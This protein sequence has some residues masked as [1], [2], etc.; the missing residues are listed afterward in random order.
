MDKSIPVVK[1]E[2]Y[3]INI[4]GL[5]YEGEGVGKLDGFTIFV[6]GALISEKVKIKIIKVNK[7][8]AYGKLLEIIEISKDR[9]EPPCNIYKKCGG[10]Q[11]QHLS[12]EGQLEFKK[13]RVK[14]C[15]SKIAKLDSNLVKDTLGMIG[16]EFRYRNK[17]QLPLANEAGE[18]K[19][20]FYAKRSHN[21]IQMD[22]C[23]IQTEVA[24]EVAKIIKTWILK[25]KISVYNEETNKGFL[26]H[27]MIRQGFTTNEVMVVLVTN[28]GEIS[29]IDELIKKLVNNISG[30]KSVIQNIN[31][32]NTNVVLG[33]KCKTLFG[34]DVISDYIGEFKFNISPLSFFQVNP[35][36]TKVLYDKAL[37]FA[38][39]TGE[40][41]V[42]DAY[43]GTGTISLFL[44]QKAKKVYGVEIVPE[45]IENAI[46]NA[47][48][49]GVKNAEF[50]V[51]ESERV[52]PELIAKGIKP[53]V[54]VVDPP[55]KGCE[56]ILLEE[57][58]KAEPR[59]IVY[60]S[61]DP[62]TLARDLVVLSEYNY[63]VLEVQPV[64]MFPSTAHVES[65]VLLQKKNS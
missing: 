29:N 41:I 6:E 12:Y 57:I 39:L 17:V 10:C 26:R 43:C 60:V 38:G 53:D 49:N 31:D 54:V 27:L 50:F 4:E 2:E 25:N 11:L 30:L 61:C 45:A 59:T 15:I 34:S 36:Q 24:D 37:E 42:F 56:R 23:L 16:S 22:N 7:N 40:E 8:F 33:Q 18:I 19:L 52:I 48:N 13:Q 3:I 44:S 1:N 64:D 46:E 14:D 47:K 9:V 51:G 20:G 28:F 5:G 32:K 35:K 65:V 63:K 62:S 55:R 21:I 58:A